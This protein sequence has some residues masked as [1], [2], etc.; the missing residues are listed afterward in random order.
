M[1]LFSLLLAAA[2]CLLAPVPAAAHYEA[3]PHPEVPYADMTYRGI[4]CDAVEAFCTRFTADPPAL[5]EALVALYDDVYTQRELAYIHMCENPADEAACAASEAASDAFLHADDAI[6][7]ALSEALDGAQ[8]E[9]LAA[10][11]PPDTA[12]GFRDYL[13]ADETELAATSEESAL[14]QAYYSLPD[15]D[16]FER[17]AAALYL[18]LAELRRNEAARAGYDSYADYAYAVYFGREYDSAD[19][20]ALERIVK[21][22]LAPLYVRC[23][24]ALDEREL[25]WDEEDVP[26]D[27]EIL[28]ALAAHMD[29][30]SPELTEALAYL[31]RNGLYRIGGAPLY[32]SGFTTSLSAYRAPFLFNCVSGRFSAFQTTVHE[33]GHFNAAYH[34]PTPV[35]FQYA[36]SDVSE[37]QSQA[38]ELLFLPCLADIL[39]GTD[40]A[41]R[42]TLT[43]YALTQML[44]SVVDGCLYDEFEQAVY[45]E[46]DLSAA[47]LDAL[48]RSL[49]RD[50]GLDALYDIS[51][52][53][54]HIPHLFEQPLYYI[55]YAVSALPA[56]DIW[57]RSRTDYA[58]AVD[59]YLDVSAVR[60]DAW[61]L[62]V[63]YDNK[64][65]DVT[66]PGEVRQLSDALR[67]ELQPLLGSTASGGGSLAVAGVALLLLGTGVLLLRRKRRQDA[68]DA[69]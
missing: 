12:D 24:L 49:Y 37:I 43:L 27:R 57:L 13:P 68:E 8:G 5:Y 58:A 29:E 47:E 9:A 65:C 25:P 39:V 1:K 19:M 36:G 23:V 54:C 7:F 17:S 3:F 60:T 55:S 46:P 62:D 40:A 33:F 66:D 35:L 67:R 20:Q 50:Y 52:Y 31:R 69:A 61:F 44:G 6:R 34:D 56:L 41:A 28:D 21:R 53:W 22:E 15:D 59:L 4:D 38:L 30:V 48:E 2:L 51:S 64:L 18:R 42:D 32:D 26:D 63:L 11:M 45:A 14:I 16:A 10:R